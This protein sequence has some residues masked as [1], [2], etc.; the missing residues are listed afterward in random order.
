MALERFKR[1]CVRALTGSVEQV[2]FGHFLE[3]FGCSYAVC[4]SCILNKIY[5]SCLRGA[6]NRYII[7]ER[8]GRFGSMLFFSCILF[9]LCNTRL[10]CGN[11][12][13]IERF[14]PQL[15]QYG[16]VHGTASKAKASMCR[17]IRVPLTVL[18]SCITQG[19]PKQRE[20]SKWCTH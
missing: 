13:K 3:Y 5:K 8:P 19:E 9:F 11:V 20:R 10:G 12:P 7:W 17:R 4:P 14:A 16:I 1:H 2:T 18:I 6:W 15:A